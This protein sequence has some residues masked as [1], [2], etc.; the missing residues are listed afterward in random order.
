MKKVKIQQC[1]F[2]KCQ[3]GK[4]N[5]IKPDEA[6]E[7][8]YREFFLEQGMMEDWQSDIPEEL[9]QHIQK[10]SLLKMPNSVICRNCK[11]RFD[12]DFGE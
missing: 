5:V 4:N 10:N 12:T 7:E 1:F 11:K 9:T 8:E 6:S 3:C 2:W